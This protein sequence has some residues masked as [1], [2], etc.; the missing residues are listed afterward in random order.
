MFY[1]Q[2]HGAINFFPSI[3]P[4]RSFKENVSC[5]LHGLIAS[6]QLFSFFEEIG[7]VHYEKEQYAIKFLKTNMNLCAKITAYETLKKENQ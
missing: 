3:D 4:T 7:I 5:F 6:K 2:Q 1:E